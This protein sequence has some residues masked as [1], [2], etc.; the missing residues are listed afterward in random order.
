MAVWVVSAIGKRQL[1]GCGRGS[2]VIIEMPTAVVL[3][4]VARLFSALLLV[5]G[6]DFV[7]VIVY[8]EERVARACL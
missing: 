7:D 5:V 4:T 3:L 2:G 1:V 6:V 8:C